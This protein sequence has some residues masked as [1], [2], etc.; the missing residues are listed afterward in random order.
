MTEFLLYINR[1]L[2]SPVLIGAMLG[3]GLYCIAAHRFAAW[4]SLARL[5]RPPAADAHALRPVQACMTSLAAAMGT[6]NITGVAT[7]LTAGGPGALFWMWI[8]ALC[9]TGLLYAENVLSCRFRR[10]GC[11]GAAAYLRGGL[12]SPV[13]AGGFAVCCIAAS[14]GMGNMTQ[15]HAMAQCLA[16]AFGIPGWVTGACAALLVLAVILGG[17]GRIGRFSA[18]VMPVLTV[19][20]LGL[21]GL[22]IWRFRTALPG[23]WADIFRDAFGMR[24]AAGGITGAA[25]RRAVSVGVRRGVFSNEAGLGSSGMLH[26]EMQGADPAFQGACSILEAAADTLVCC[27]ATALAILCSGAVASGEDGS[28]LVLCAF[29]AGI[30]PAADLLVPCVISLFALC[31]LIGWSYCGSSALRSLAGQRFALPYRIAYA[32]A[33]LP[34]AVMA[35]TNVWTLADIANAGMLLCNLPALLLLYPALDR[36]APSVVQCKKREGRDDGTEQP[37]GGSDPV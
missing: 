20:Y 1:L 16:A 14:F 2:W 33:C 3:A 28:A 26:G 13:L 11:T 32:A 7:A 31:T 4:R 23:V 5:R 12:H 37:Q 36:T 34:G 27:T 25:V 29:R 9:G 35:L 17:T 24:A 15:S 10:D 18:A 8:A 21:C 6:G 19:L 30:G 22:V